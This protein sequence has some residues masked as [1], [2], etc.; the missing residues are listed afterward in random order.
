MI[1]FLFLAP[2]LPLQQQQR[3]MCGLGEYRLK[4][5]YQNLLRETDVDLLKCEKPANIGAFLQPNKK[6]V[7]ICD[8]NSFKSLTSLKGSTDTSMYMCNA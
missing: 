8:N 4:S 2:D 1:L 3:G 7:C 5:N 6:S